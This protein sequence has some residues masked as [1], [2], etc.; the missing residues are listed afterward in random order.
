MSGGWK[1]SGSGGQSVG[2]QRVKKSMNG[3]SEGQEVRESGNLRVGRSEGHEVKESGG[4]RVRRSKGQE[5]EGSWGPRV[6]KS[7]SQEVRES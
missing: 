1:V 7:E 6:R 3:K 4:Q 2:G 5:V